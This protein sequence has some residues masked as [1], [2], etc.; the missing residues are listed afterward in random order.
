MRKAAGSILGQ[1]RRCD[2]LFK[3]LQRRLVGFTEAQGHRAHILEG[4]I[5]AGH[6]ADPREPISER[7]DGEAEECQQV[8]DFIAFEEAAEV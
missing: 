3:L 6:S 8:S 1:F 4:E 7:V 2:D 5:V